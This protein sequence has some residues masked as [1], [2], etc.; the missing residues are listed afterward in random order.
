MLP[1]SGLAIPT[2]QIVEICHRYQVRELS[3]FGSAA[4]GDMRPDSAIDLLVEFRPGAIIG[5]QFFR[6]EEE[7]S[8]VFGRRVDLGT[9]CS[10][11]PWL[12]AQ[13]LRDAQTI[14]AACDGV[15]QGRP[16]RV[17]AELREF[18]GR[19]TQERFLASSLEQSY[20]FYRLVIFGETMSHVAATFQGKY[21]ELPWSAVISLQQPL[22]PFVFDL[23]L[24]L[25]W[26]IATTQVNDIALQ[27]RTILETEVPGEAE[28]GPS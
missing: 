2:E 18:A 17:G 1:K 23:D 19:A 26:S 9:K 6:L 14:Y 4:R 5:W 27:L 24:P 8:Q 13:V 21:A 10:L 28:G 15:P 11:K 3:L 25:A 20:V 22:G 12:R 7:L 16:A